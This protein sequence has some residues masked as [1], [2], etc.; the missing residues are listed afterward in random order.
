[1]TAATAAADFRTCPRTNLKIHAAADALIKANAVAATVALL[2]G[3]IAAILVLLT[4]WQA[5]HSV[6]LPVCP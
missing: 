4:R 6:I 2:I 1:M 5:V 3:G